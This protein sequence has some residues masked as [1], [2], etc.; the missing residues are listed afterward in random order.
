LGNAKLIN[1]ELILNASF[2]GTRVVDGRPGAVVETNLTKKV[3][4]NSRLHLAARAVHK[5]G[6]FTNTGPLP[7]SA[8]V[9]TSYTIIWSV[10]NSSNELDNLVLKTTLPSQSKWLNVVSPLGENVDYNPTNGEVTW[11]AGRVPVDTS[12]APVK[13]L[14]FQVGFTPSANQ[15]GSTP[16]LIGPTSISAIDGFTGTR[17]SSSVIGLSILTT[18]DPGFNQSLG[19]VAP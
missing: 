13:E 17:L 11:S 2:R 4:L 15:V 5:S 10:S 8:G 6:P 7:P 19:V 1:P 14:Y 16:K 9:E 3:R 12:G 18:T